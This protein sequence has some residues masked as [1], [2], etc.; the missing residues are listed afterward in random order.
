MYSSVKIKILARSKLV[1]FEQAIFNIL[2]WLNTWKR[3]SIILF[4]NFELSYIKKYF[5]EEPQSKALR[6]FFSIGNLLYWRGH[7]PITKILIH[8][9][10]CD[11]FPDQSFGV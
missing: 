11:T 8:I 3:D 9:F 7:T 1:A 10:T 5:N 4:K 2:L 6:F